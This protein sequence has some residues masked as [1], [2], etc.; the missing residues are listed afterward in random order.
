M[1][2]QSIHDR[3]N[4]LLKDSTL[5]E[6][7]QFTDTSLT[8]FTS[9]SHDT[10]FLKLGATDFDQLYYSGL[11]SSSTL[12]DSN[13]ITWILKHIQ[14]KTL[15]SLTDTNNPLQGVKIA[16]DPG[17]MAGDM[18]MAKIEGKFIEF[19]HKA[20]P[21]SFYEAHL[22]LCTALMMKEQLEQLGAKVLI[23]R[24]KPGIA[25]HGSTFYDWYNIKVYETI[26]SLSN[27]DKLTEDESRY[28]KKVR[29]RN[30]DLSKKIIYNRLFKYIDYR[31]R[32][33][34][35]N[36]FQPH[37][38]LIIHY[39]V[40]AENKN[41]KQP[42]PRNFTMAFIPG[43]FVEDELK[44]PEDQLDFLRLLF[45]QDIENSMSFSS[46]IVQSLHKELNIPLANQQSEQYLSD[47]SIATNE[48]GVFARNL[49]LTRKVHGTI[50]YAE[51]LY[52]DNINEYLL[53]N[54]TN[55]NID[56]LKCSDRL[57]TA[58]NAYIKG[59]LNYIDHKRQSYE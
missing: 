30:T 58:A 42:S 53:L 7:I 33:E 12:T 26:D 16:L 47:Y 34:K 15:P 19:D 37:L 6:Q 31:A 1:S 52:Q 54:Q 22:T 8:L 38:T 2:A 46:F 20:K 4:I 17:H 18:E 36:N 40:D 49:S 35:I 13:K 55:V 41:W 48:K 5:L 32:A 45:S 27:I 39:N 29:R 14:P 28:L 25:A 56:Q 24:E 23:T 44:D 10:T 50:C 11:S 3:L 9:S 51:A 59:I 21:I 43:S 57:I